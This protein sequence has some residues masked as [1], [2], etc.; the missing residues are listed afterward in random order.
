MPG[1]FDDCRNG[2]LCSTKGGEL[3]NQLNVSYLL[4]EH[5]AQ[6]YKEPWC[7]EYISINFQAFSQ[8]FCHYIYSDTSANE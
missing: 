4:V 3:H 5:F 7:F 8:V 2:S 6:Y 1:C